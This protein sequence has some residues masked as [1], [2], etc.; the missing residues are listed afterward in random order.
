[1]LYFDVLISKMG[2]LGKCVMF[3]KRISCGGGGFRA[4]L[5]PDIL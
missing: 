2:V 4:G 3:I 1:M 5:G